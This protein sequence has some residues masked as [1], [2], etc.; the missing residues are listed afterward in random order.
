MAKTQ[1][2]NGANFRPHTYMPYYTF[3]DVTTC[4][5]EQVYNMKIISRN[6]AA[7]PSRV[8]IYEKRNNAITVASA[9]GRRT[10]GLPINSNNSKIEREKNESQKAQKFVVIEDECEGLAR[11]AD[12][13]V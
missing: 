7:F 10:L 4:Q 6:N 11:N 1:H 2:E 13:A 9:V 8:L 12:T 3:T 5:F